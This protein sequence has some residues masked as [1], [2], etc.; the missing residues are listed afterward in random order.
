MVQEGMVQEGMKQEGKIGL[1]CWQCLKHF[2]IMCCLTGPFHE[3][4]KPKLHQKIPKMPKISRSNIS[5]P[6]DPKK[7]K[8]KKSKKKHRSR[9]RSKSRSKAPTS[10]TSK[11]IIDLDPNNGVITE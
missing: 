1:T 10:T 11:T 5:N 7:E 3:F 4:E 9:S 8:A 2:S 6:P